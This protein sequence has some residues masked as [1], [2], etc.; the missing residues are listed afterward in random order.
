MKKLW[1]LALLPLL[2]IFGCS[3]NT[4][5]EVYISDSFY[6]LISDFK[7]VT[8]QWRNLSFMEFRDLYPEYIEQRDIILD[9][10][11]LIKENPQ[12]T[13]SEI[14]DIAKKDYPDLLDPVIEEVEIT[15]EETKKGVDFE[16]KVMCSNRLN[17]LQQL[18]DN[19]FPKTSLLSPSIVEIFYSPSEDTCIWLV[20][21]LFKNYKDWEVRYK[22]SH[23]YDL[24]TYKHSVYR[25]CIN[26]CENAEQPLNYF[27]YNLEVNRLKASQ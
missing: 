2:F 18:I 16:K 11:Q 26:N 5:P 19:D 4:Q 12:Y 3:K 20:D 21:A 17:Q 9:F 27:S 25:I 24:Y 10:F 8:N 14:I 7:N 15:P 23:I 22:F 6:D 1:I 13:E